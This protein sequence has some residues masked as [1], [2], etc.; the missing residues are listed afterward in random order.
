LSSATTQLANNATANS[1]KQRR[2]DI[3]LTCV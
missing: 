1:E 3:D 2:I